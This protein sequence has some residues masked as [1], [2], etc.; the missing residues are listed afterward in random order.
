MLSIKR[1]SPI[2]LA[3]LITASL[4]T[5]GDPGS[6]VSKRVLDFVSYYSGIWDNELQ[7]QQPGDDHA[8][9]Q[10]RVV[11]VDIE[12]FM[13]NPVLF[14]EESINGVLKVFFLLVLTEDI[15]DTVSLAFYTFANESNYKPREFKVESFSNMS[16]GAFHRVENCTGSF[17]VAKGYAFG[18]FPE[19]LY[20]IGGK[21]PRFTLLLRCDS[22]TVTIPQNTDQPSPIESYEF[23]HTGPKFS[24]L[25]PPKGYV[26]PCEPKIKNIANKNSLE[27]STS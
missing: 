15:E 10:A 8:F 4:A 26:A 27:P 18:N 23:L 13:P 3:S 2:I 19:C 14:A 24:V 12:C 17:R 25:N 5:A 9:V 16:C 6:G 21:H 1:I 7:T 22:I 20:T 11:P